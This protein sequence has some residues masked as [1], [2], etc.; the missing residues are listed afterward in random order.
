MQVPLPPAA[1]TEAR[2]TASLCIDSL[3]ALEIVQ[4]MNQEDAGVAAAV[5]TE[6]TAIAQAVDLIAQRFRAGGRLIYMG[7]G[8]SGRLGVLD[9]SECPPTFSVKP[10]MVIGLI[11]GGKAALTSAIEGAEDRRDEGASDLQQLGLTANDV[12]MGIASSGR[13][14]YVIGGLEYARSVNAATI[15]F[16]CNAGSALIPLSDIMIAPIV[17]PEVVTGSTRLKAGTATKMVLNMLTTGA[18]VLIGK[19]YGNLMV[20]LTATNEKLKDRSQRIVAELT[21]LTA[22]AAGEL[23]GRC[24]GQVKTAVVAHQKQITP[25]QAREVLKTHSQHLRRALESLTSQ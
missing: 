13:T 24:D 10:G 14:P 22:A 12:V 11:A 23:L 16:A 21:G 2:N 9:A 19:T 3:S 6:S 18:M 4:L 1:S 17:G 7:A 15:G 8:T 25:E 20:D 5:A